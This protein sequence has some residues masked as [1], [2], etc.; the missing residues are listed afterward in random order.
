MYSKSSMETDLELCPMTSQYSKR[1]RDGFP[2]FE[3]DLIKNIKNTKLDE[4]KIEQTH[5]IGR[6]A[7]GGV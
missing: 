7:E 1:N 5:K 2:K 3:T 4:P 6:L